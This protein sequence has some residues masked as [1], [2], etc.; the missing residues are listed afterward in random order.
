[1]ESG[2][3]KKPSLECLYRGL[4]SL[5]IHID[6]LWRT[7]QSFYLWWIILTIVAYDSMTMLEPLIIIMIF[8]VEK[9][10]EVRS[11]IATRHSRG[12]YLVQALRVVFLQQNRKK[13]PTPLAPTATTITKARKVSKYHN[14]I[15]TTPSTIW[16]GPSATVNLHS[17]SYHHNHL[18]RIK[19][20]CTFYTFLLPFH[21][22]KL[23]PHCKFFQNIFL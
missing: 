1:M 15:H 23:F 17:L 20:L 19:T 21:H 22:I 10:N 13:A 6:N 5:G 12:K 7:L 16:V 18:H 14:N 11:L 3:S 4:V 9:M 8:R 2:K